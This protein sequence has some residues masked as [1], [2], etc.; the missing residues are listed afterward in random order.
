MYKKD[1]EV[2]YL[3][4]QKLKI[5]KKFTKKEYIFIAV[6][7]CAGLLLIVLSFFTGN[8]KKK[9]V[10][11]NIES[12]SGMTGGS[13]YIQFYEDR[14]T[15][16]IAHIDGISGVQVMI[17]LESTSELVYAKNEQLRENGGEDGTRD[18]KSDIAL[19]EDEKKAESPILLKEN[20]PKIKGAAVV[21]NGN[22]N[23]EL[24]IIKLIS[25]V[26]GLSSN[27]IQIIINN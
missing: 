12:S 20:E 17:T 3:N 24:K 9:E 1:W 15:A 11:D 14:L 27:R 22:V 25:A 21:C 19:Y 16:L 4:A 23:D 6:G 2:G 8:D 10:P 13:D 26:L 7:I 5:L 18:Y